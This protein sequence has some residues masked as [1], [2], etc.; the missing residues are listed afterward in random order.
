MGGDAQKYADL[1]EKLTQCV[2]AGDLAGAEALIDELTNARETELFFELG[3]LTR[4]LHESLKTFK[5]DSR[6]FELAESEIPDAR[7]RLN[8][9]IAMT[10]QAAHRTLNEIED[11]MTLVGNITDRGRELQENWLRFRRRDMSVSEF[12]EYSRELDDFFKQVDSQGGEVHA[13]LTEA[14]MAQDYQDLTGQIIRRVINLVQ[15]VEESLVDL[16]R[17]SGARMGDEK[18]KA[19]DNKKTE[20]AVA[21]PSAGQGPHIPGGADDAQFV[22]DQDGVDDLLSSLGF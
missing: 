13:K 5:M 15:E 9:V 7:D 20:Q 17:I 22:Q 21:V 11:S 10:E 12:R 8:Y 16:V 19:A 3:R 1:A 18:R 6:V 2:N 4:E 14:L